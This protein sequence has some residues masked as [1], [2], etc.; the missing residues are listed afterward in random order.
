MILPTHR[1]DLHFVPGDPD[2]YPILQAAELLE[3]LRA[4]EVIDGSGYP[5]RGADWLVPGGFKRLRIDDPGRVVLYSNQIGG[6]RVACPVAPE[7]VVAAFRAALIAW[8][9]GG[10]R[11]LACPACGQEHA[12]EDLEYRPAAA[13]G[14]LSIAIADVED[15]NPTPEASEFIAGALGPV[16]L[17]RRRV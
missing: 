7:N 3:V 14:R 11:Q 4:R 5:L 17:V 15:A 13:F 1:L 9:S 10:P 8:R 16:R 2:A 6:F 12:L